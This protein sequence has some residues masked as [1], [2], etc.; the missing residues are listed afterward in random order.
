MSCSIY[1]TKNLRTISGAL[2]LTAIQ[3]SFANHSF[4]SAT[5]ISKESFKLTS[6]NLIF[7]VRASFPTSED[8]FGQILL[9]PE[10]YL[11]NN[12]QIDGMFVI[13]VNRG[14][15]L[16]AGYSYPSYPSEFV[17]RFD[18]SPKIDLF[19]KFMIKFD[20][21]DM[22]FDLSWSPN[23]IYYPRSDSLKI[24]C[25]ERQA[26]STLLKNG[27]FRLLIDLMVTNLLQG[28][29][30]D[31]VIENSKKWW[32][33]SM[34]I[35]YIR[36]YD[37]GQSQ[38]MDNFKYYNSSVE[39]RASDIFNQVSIDLGRKI[40]N[41]NYQEGN[42]PFYVIYPILLIGIL[43]LTYMAYRMSNMQREMIRARTFENTHDLIELPNILT[44]MRHNS[45]YSI[46]NKG[47]NEYEC[48]PYND[49][50]FISE[51]DHIVTNNFNLS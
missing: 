12:S 10:Q 24:Y 37:L 36:V 5:I 34:I 3:E 21:T 2:V 44:P 1:R 38:I 27:K 6:S 32:C 14:N 33:T 41:Q 23:G 28:G 40:P 20:Y 9:T 49:T 18:K 50:M 43:L 22:R 48:I 8:V 7:E 31:K 47:I 4:T 13:L 17:K 25:K 26:C 45:I 16:N 30:D 42:I 39:K 35:D 15:T 46:N 11:F 19:T 29:H 51:Q